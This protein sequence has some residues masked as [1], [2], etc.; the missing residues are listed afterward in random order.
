MV[1][2]QYAPGPD[3]SLATWVTKTV[4]LAKPEQFTPQAWDYMCKQVLQPGQTKKVSSWLSSGCSPVGCQLFA[5]YTDSAYLDSGYID[6]NCPMV[7]CT[8]YK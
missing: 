8:T 2:Q 3:N 5:P 6:A 7:A 4:G 1:E